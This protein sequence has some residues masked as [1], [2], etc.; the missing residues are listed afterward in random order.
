MFNSCLR[1]LEQDLG[2][3]VGPLLVVLE[4]QKIRQALGA[5]TENPQN[6]VVLAFAAGAAL[7]ATMSAFPEAKVIVPDAQEWKGSVP[8]KIHQARILKA[9]GWE[10]QKRSDYMTVVG[11]PKDLIGRDVIGAEI[12][13]SSDW[14]HVLDG[15]GLA[16]WGQRQLDLAHNL[17]EIERG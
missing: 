12:I 8:K 1:L 5:Q 7:G 13:K 14:K 2:V 10:G 6:I 9:Q 11:D 4:G 3:S 17:T 16:H 15:V